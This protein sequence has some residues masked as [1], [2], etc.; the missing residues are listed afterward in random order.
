M[1][2]PFCKKSYIILIPTTCWQV[3]QSICL[4]NTGW[5][6]LRTSINMLF[7]S[8]VSSYSR[9]NCPSLSFLGMLSTKVKGQVYYP[10]VIRL[11]KIYRINV[12]VNTTVTL[13]LI[14]LCRYSAVEQ[15]SAA[16][17]C[18]EMGGP[19]C[20]MSMPTATGTLIYTTSQPAVIVSTTGTL[21][22]TTS[23]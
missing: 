5:P 9:S 23:M 19:I 16:L 13:L 20:F 10:Y 14:Q 17:S 18:W 3:K 12:T 8:I 6:D 15:R 1:R 22:T 21:H 4:K 2:Q 7:G 11:F